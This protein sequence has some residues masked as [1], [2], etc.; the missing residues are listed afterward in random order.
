[1]SYLILALSISYHFKSRRNKYWLAFAGCFLGGGLLELIQK[2]FIVG[3]TASLDDQVLNC[4]GAVIGIILFWLLRKFN[5]F[6]S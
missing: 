5:F 3:R 2:F 1:M 4:I 6:K